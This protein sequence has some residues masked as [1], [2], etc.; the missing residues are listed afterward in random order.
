MGM[1]VLPWRPVER[2]RPPATAV[3]CDY[4]A[5]L[6]RHHGDPDVTI[7]KRLDHVSKLFVH[8]PAPLR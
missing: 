1:L 8:L 6:E 3:L 5:Y 7:R 4:A 2:R